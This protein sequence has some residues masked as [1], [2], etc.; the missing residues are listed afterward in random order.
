MQTTLDRDDRQADTSP[1]IPPTGDTGL[2][3]IFDLWRDLG[4]SD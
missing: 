2:D 3:D 4:G 1:S